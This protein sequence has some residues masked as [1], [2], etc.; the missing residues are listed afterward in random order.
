MYAKALG[1][2]EDIS[3]ANSNIFSETA[4]NSPLG[5]GIRDF[6]AHGFFNLD[7]TSIRYLLGASQATTSATYIDYTLKDDFAWSNIMGTHQKT[8]VAFLG[9]NIINHALHIGNPDNTWSTS[10]D[11]YTPLI[12]APTQMT[13]SVGEGISHSGWTLVEGTAT[14]FTSF[15]NTPNGN[16]SGNRVRVAIYNADGEGEDK[17]LNCISLGTIYELQSPDAQL[18]ISREYPT[19]VKKK[20]LNGSEYTNTLMPRNPRWGRLNAWEIES[21]DPDGFAT[22]ELS[23]HKN[24]ARVGR[25]T[26][27]LNFS[28]MSGE[29]IYPDNENSSTIIQNAADYESIYGTDTIV[30]YNPYDP[31]GNQT[32]KAFD[33]LGE[34]D[35]FISQVWHKT[36][37]GQLKFIFQADGDRYTPDQFMIAKFKENS[38]EIVRTSPNTHQISVEIEESF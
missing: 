21:G 37:G 3:S 15:V 14:N 24:P 19:Q 1:L 12:N 35:S 6:D 11:N 27:K 31:M 34:D 26:Y 23:Q 29:T 25:R 22:E 7:P 36:L 2:T 38:L 13:D 33:S 8:Y 20:A 16:W 9:H 17:Y 30:T 4:P 32:S 28:A 18:T 10:M 5:D